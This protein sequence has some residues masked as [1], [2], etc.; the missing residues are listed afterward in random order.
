MRLCKRSPKRTNSWT[1]NWT[2]P[3]GDAPVQFNVA[4]NAPN[5]DDS[6]LG[7]YIYLKVVRSAPPKRASVA[8]AS[9]TRNAKAAAKNTTP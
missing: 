2:A 6:P 4:A 7:D 5:D 3:S 8:E 1:V 9:G